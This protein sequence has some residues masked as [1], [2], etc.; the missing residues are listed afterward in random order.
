MDIP[1][2]DWSAIAS[3]LAK[4]AVAYALALPVGWDREKEARSA[5]L[6]TFPLV[7]VASCGYMLFAVEIFAAE[8]EAQARLVEETEQR[9]AIE[10]A[11]ADELEVEV[12][13][14]TRE[15]E[16]AN[17]DKD[18]ILTVIGHDLRGP[19]TGLTQTAELLTS[20]GGVG[21]GAA[22]PAALDGF[23]GDAAKLGRQVLLLIEDLVLW[24]RLRTG[25][26]SPPTPHRVRAIVAPVVALH[27]TLAG[28][29]GIALTVEVAEELRVTTDLVLAQ[30]LLRNLVANALKFARGEVVVSA[31]ARSETEGG[32]TELTVRDDGP[33]LPA[34]VLAGFADGAGAGAGA[35]GGLGLRLC[36]EIGRALDANVAVQSIRGNGTEFKFVLPTAAPEASE[37]ERG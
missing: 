35:E 19:L 25:R 15:L 23:A 16:E 13:E 7:A 8:P 5:G 37:I 27:R 33:G 29:R 4:I 1:L 31:R 24:A 10:E 18:R 22:S 17:T 30:T 9:R 11:Y 21:A 2:I 6:R 14:R 3:S 32:G 36:I 34:A 28:Q 20:G 12:R 26:A